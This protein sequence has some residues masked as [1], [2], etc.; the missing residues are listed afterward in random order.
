MEK[1]LRKSKESWYVS[2]GDR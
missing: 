2:E 1:T